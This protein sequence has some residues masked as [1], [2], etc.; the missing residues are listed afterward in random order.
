[1]AHPRRAPDFEPQRALAAALPG[2]TEDIKWGADLVY[3]VGGKMFCVFLLEVGR[4]ATCSLK[5]DDERFLELTGVPGVVPAPYL[6]RA[7]WV[8]VGRI[9]GLE[10]ADLDALV[11]RSHA[12]V[13]S[14]LTKKLQRD[15][16]IDAGEPATP[17]RPAAKP[18]PHGERTVKA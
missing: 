4:A 12:L 5:V 1:M 9:H 6:A 15:I 2:A 14:R 18:G 7:K 17:H 10:G 16:G 13:A 11:R 8:Q 3:S